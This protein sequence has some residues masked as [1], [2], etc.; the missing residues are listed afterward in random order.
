M[1]RSKKFS[2]LDAAFASVLYVTLTNH[3]RFNLLVIVECTF[4]IIFVVSGQIWVFINRVFRESLGCC[5]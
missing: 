4:V 3:S 1:F 5:F 2:D